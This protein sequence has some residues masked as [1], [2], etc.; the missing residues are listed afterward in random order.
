MTIGW[1][2]QTG[3]F[4][5]GAVVSLSSLLLRKSCLAEMSPVGNRIRI[6]NGEVISRLS[7]VEMSYRDR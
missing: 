2:V 6:R 7:N 4:L 3:D 5:G 1:T